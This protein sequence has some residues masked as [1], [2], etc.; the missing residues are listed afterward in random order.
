[1]KLKVAVGLLILFM[2]GMTVLGDRGLFK[3]LRLK[4][5][6]QALVLERDRLQADNERL[7]ADIDRLDHDYDYIERVAREEFGMVRPGEFIFLF[8]DRTDAPAGRP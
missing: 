2:L 5:Q 4:R 8:S 1:M 7:R 6:R 3:L